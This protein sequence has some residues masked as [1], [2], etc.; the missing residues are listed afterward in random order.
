MWLC[1][2]NYINYTLI[3][4]VKSNENNNTH[5]IEMYKQSK[6]NH[7]SSREMDLA[8][9]VCLMMKNEHISTFAQSK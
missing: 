9:S 3:L 4:C 1:K 6:L 2:L 8:S 7:Q 5:K